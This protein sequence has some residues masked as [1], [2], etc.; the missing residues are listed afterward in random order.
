MIKGPADHKQIHFPDHSTF[1]PAPMSATSSCCPEKNG[2]LWAI[3]PPVGLGSYPRHDQW[4][5]PYTLGFDQPFYEGS[6]IITPSVTTILLV[7]NH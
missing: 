2:G 1:F 4:D 7:V 3:E 6:G 5:L